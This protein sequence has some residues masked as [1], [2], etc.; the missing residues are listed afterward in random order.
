MKNSFFILPHKN[1]AR[2]TID[3]QIIKLQSKKKTLGAGSKWDAYRLFMIS[4]MQLIGNWSNFCRN[5]KCKTN[6]IRFAFLPLKRFLTKMCIISTVVIIIVCTDHKC[7]EM[8]WK[9][10]IIL[11]I[12]MRK[13]MEK[14]YARLLSKF[15]N[16]FSLFDCRKSLFNYDDE[17][18]F[19]REFWWFFVN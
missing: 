2:I 1:G 8:F 5:L 10:N 18:V 4:A 3:R 11:I 12:A 14:N 16:N 19:F 7:L 15:F 17:K 13:I 6:S 9:R